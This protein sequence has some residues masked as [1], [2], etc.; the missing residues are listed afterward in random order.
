MADKLTSWSFSRYVVYRE[1]P[2][3]A[4]YKFIEKLPEPGSAA[5][6]RGT[7]IHTKAEHYIRGNLSRLPKELLPLGR[8][9]RR[10]RAEYKQAPTRMLMEQTWAFTADWSHTRWD[11]WRGCALRIKVD[12]AE[13][14]E[15]AILVTDWKTG[16]F[17]D[18]KAAEYEEQL[19][20]YALGALLWFPDV[21]EVH[22]RLAYIDEGLLHPAETNVTSR[23]EQTTLRKTWE[24]RTRKMLTDTQFK[25]TPSAACR[26]CHFRSGNGGPCRAG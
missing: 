17:R 16:K 8:E 21:S 15:D 23:K 22:T 1:C 2:A 6:D 7:E 12:L 11:D 5:M 20:L 19:E 26:W 4:R 13:I 10:L 14:G 9:F 24:K 3:K 18:S 25:P